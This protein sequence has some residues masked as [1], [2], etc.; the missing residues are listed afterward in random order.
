LSRNAGEKLPLP[1]A[2]HPRR[3]HFSSALSLKLEFTHNLFEL[4][5]KKARS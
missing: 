3:A 5:R 4:E 1:A 2:Q